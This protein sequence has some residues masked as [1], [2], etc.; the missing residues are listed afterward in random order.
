MVHRDI[1]PSNLLVQPPLGGAAA[2]GGVVK[3]TDFGLARLGEGAADD[4]PIR[5]PGNLVMGTPDYLSPEQGRDLAETD[6][7][8]DLYSLG[9]TLYFLLSGEVPFPGGTSLEKLMRHATVEP[10]PVE[11]LRPVVPPRVAA[12]VRRLMAK[13]PAERFQTPAELAEA[14]EPFAEVRP[15]VWTAAREVSLTIATGAVDLLAAPE[16]AARTHG[17]SILSGTQIAGQT[18]TLADDGRKLSGEELR[19]LRGSVVRR[20]WVRL[21]LFLL[22]VVIGFTIGVLSITSGLTGAR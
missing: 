16:G 14:L 17:T 7:R 11:Q 10:E 9:C 2:A 8:S 12:V 3:I 19:V 6:I 15:V 5:P 21:V 13:Q 18:A 22:A 4:A 1:K 20:H